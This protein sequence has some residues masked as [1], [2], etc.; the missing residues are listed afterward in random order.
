MVAAMM[1]V[2]LHKEQHQE[3]ACEQLLWCLR[4]YWEVQDTSR[5]TKMRCCAG[6]GVAAGVGLC[7]CHKVLGSCG[8][9]GG[10]GKPLE[11]EQGEQRSP[12][13]SWALCARKEKPGVGVGRRQK[14]LGLIF[15]GRECH[16]MGIVLMLVCFRLSKDFH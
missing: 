2:L 10:A 7:E 5:V 9:P 6:P 14:S 4:Q 12:E 1:R 16:V 3:H 15:S 11:K 8:V 13:A